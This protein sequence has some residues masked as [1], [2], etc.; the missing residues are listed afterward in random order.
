MI[1]VLGLH[2]T[3]VFYIQKKKTTNYK[4]AES[5]PP[6]HF[7]PWQKRAR[8]IPRQ[9]SIAALDLPPLEVVQQTPRRID[10]SQTY[11]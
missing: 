2:V 8:Q 11:L 4:E 10:T 9:K 1:K 7:A 6:Q 3:K 5:T